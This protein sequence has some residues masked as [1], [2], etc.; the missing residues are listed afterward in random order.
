VNKTL[1]EFE[2]NFR[3]LDTLIF[4]ETSRKYNLS[5]SELKFRLLYPNEESIIEMH[6]CYHANADKW[7]ILKSYHKDSAYLRSIY[8]MIDELTILHKFAGQPFIL[9]FY[10]WGS[11]GNNTMFSYCICF[12]VMDMNLREFYSQFI[13]NFSYEDFE[14]ALSEGILGYISCVVLNAL[15]EIRIKG[16]AHRNINSNNILL[17]DRGEVKLCGFSCANK[18][19]VINR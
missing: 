4:E 6:I 5:Y 12:E 11:I 13:N 15:M 16:F 18:Y 1:F 9:Q 19:G 2:E 7:I 3:K 17:N 10:G 8:C 14:D